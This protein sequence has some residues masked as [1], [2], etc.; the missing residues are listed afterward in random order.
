M[1]TVFWDV[2]PCVLVHIC[3]RNQ[4]QKAN[5]ILI[6]TTQNIRSGKWLDINELHQQTLINIINWIIQATAMNKTTAPL[7]CSQHRQRTFFGNVGR[8]LLNDKM[9]HTRRLYVIFIATDVRIS[10]LRNI[11]NTAIEGMKIQNFGKV[12]MSF[13][14]YKYLVIKIGYYSI[15][16]K[17]KSELSESPWR[18]TLQIPYQGYVNI[19]DATSCRVPRLSACHVVTLTNF[20]SAKYFDL[21]WALSDRYFCLITFKHTFLFLK[22]KRRLLRSPCSVS[23]Y[24]SVYV[25]HNF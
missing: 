19:A 25:S 5:Y 10:D 16:K 24:P 2:T 7:V 6:Y 22:N 1:I 21:M 9:S 14:R 20:I 18:P 13:R 11:K 17:L 8:H 15:R 23:V 3:Q 12:T 4:E